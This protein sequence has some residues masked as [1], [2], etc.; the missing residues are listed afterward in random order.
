LKSFAF[1]FCKF[2]IGGAQTVRFAPVVPWAKV[3]PARKSVL[4][5]QR[6]VISAN[7][8][9]SLELSNL[10]DETSETFYAFKGVAS[11]LLVSVPLGVITYINTRI[12]KYS[13]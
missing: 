1:F 4:A 11:L 5:D 7:C 9:S 3:G 8:S 10:R 13:V 6:R 12:T 2:F